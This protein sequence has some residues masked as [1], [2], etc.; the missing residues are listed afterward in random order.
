MNSRMH[1]QK[2][3]VDCILRMERIKQVLLMEGLSKLSIFVLCKNRKRKNGVLIILFISFTN[4]WNVKSLNRKWSRRVSKYFSFVEY[5]KCQ[6]IDSILRY[7][8]GYFI[9]FQFYVRKAV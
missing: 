6:N 1:F 5:M 7:L 4:L 3:V 2:I 9:T 8:K